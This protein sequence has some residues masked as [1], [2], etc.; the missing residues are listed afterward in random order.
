MPLPRHETAVT[1]GP[2]PD[3]YRAAKAALSF[4]HRDWS[5][6][7]VM[8]LVNQLRKR[9]GD[10]IHITEPAYLWP[11]ATAHFL[12][13]T[14][15]QGIRNP[16]TYCLNAEGEPADTDRQRRPASGSIGCVAQAAVRGSVVAEVDRPGLIDRAP[17]DPVAF[18]EVAHPAIRAPHLLESD[19]VT[20]NAERQGDLLIGRDHGRKAQP[21]ARGGRIG[22]HAL[23]L[24]GLRRLLNRLARIASGQRR[25]KNHDR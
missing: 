3:Q 9:C 25:R 22:L 1:A 19:D 23:C 11:I 2:L 18:S 24:N 12:M 13:R 16:V 10:A 15:K 21:A 8:D 7:Q 5:F 4:I 20:G 17:G 6:T 14:K